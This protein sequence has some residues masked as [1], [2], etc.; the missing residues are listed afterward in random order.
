MLYMC[1]DLRYME[2]TKNLQVNDK[3][4]LYLSSNIEEYGWNPGNLTTS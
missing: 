3:Y 1:F 4:I 2:E